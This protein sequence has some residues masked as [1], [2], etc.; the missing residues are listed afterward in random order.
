MSFVLAQV[1]V[2]RLTAPLD[3]PALAE[4]VAAL[5]PV[6]ALAEAAPGFLW[7]LQTEDG[8]ATAIRAFDWDAG[9]SAG[10]IVN[11]SVWES[12]EALAAFVYSPGHLAVLQRR[13]QWFERMSVA[14]LALWWIPRST[15]PTVRQAEDRVRH[16]RSHGP[17]QHAFTLRVHFPPPD[18]TDAAPRSGRADWLCPALSLR[19]LAARLDMRSNGP[20]PART[21]GHVQRRALCR[22]VTFQAGWI[23]AQSFA[24]RL[25]NSSSCSAL[26]SST[27]GPVI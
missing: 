18:A 8:N 3:S 25:P 17:T 26:V 19:T 7:R 11:M 12:V 14:H 15:I 13:R 4:F 21:R 6:N 20:R 1:N 16:L 10:V 2:G 24:L 9:E 22:T 23:S 5:D 27:H